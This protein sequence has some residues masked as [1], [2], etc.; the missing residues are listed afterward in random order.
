MMGSIFYQSIRLVFGVLNPAYNSFKAVKTKNVKEYVHW[1]TYWIVLAVLTIAEEVTDILLGCWFPLYTEIKLVFLFWL[2]S[3]ITRGSII[4]Y[5]KF[6]H[7]LLL[8]REAEIDELIQLWREQSYQLGIKYTK[9]AAEKITKTVL[10]TAISGGNGIISSLQH[11]YSMNDL[12][13]ASLTSEVSEENRAVVPK[14]TMSMHRRERPHHSQS[15]VARHE[16]QR[17][18][19]GTVTSRST[20]RTNSTEGAN[21]TC[22]LYGTLP[23]STRRRAPV[24]VGSLADPRRDRKRGSRLSLNSL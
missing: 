16:T 7:P 9:V 11:S 1:M 17:K 10:Q 19:T 15:P 4:V 3:P 12:R 24:E 21:K 5:R 22:S 18:R 14:R 13:R 6:I 2:L 20:S 23:R 8:Q